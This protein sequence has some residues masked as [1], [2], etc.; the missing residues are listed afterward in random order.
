MG[1]A[2]TDVRGLRVGHYTDGV[3]VTGCTAVL[4]PDGTVASGEVRGGAPGTREF[5]LLSPERLVAHIDAVMLCGGSAFG[6]AATDGAVRFCEERGMGL[7]TR[8]G[9]VP[10]VVGMV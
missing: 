9:P 2:I 5:A 6:L 7:A 4:F 3:A 8:A 10:I 1:G